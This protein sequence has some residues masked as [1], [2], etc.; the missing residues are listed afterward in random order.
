MSKLDRVTGRS[1]VPDTMAEALTFMLAGAALAVVQGVVGALS[2][3]NRP[4]VAAVS[5]ASGVIVGGIWWW[6][7][8]VCRQGRDGGRVLGSVFFALSTFGIMQTLTGQFH[9][10][11][12]LTIVDVLSWL[13]GLGAVVMLW[14]RDSTAFFQS[15]RRFPA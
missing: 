11:P 7:A 3:L 13:A 6:V 8:R 1:A 4:V 9:V 12:V 15:S 2:E 10:R 14:Q 5:L